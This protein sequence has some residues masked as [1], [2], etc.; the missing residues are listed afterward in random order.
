MFG[1]ILA[2]LLTVSLIVAVF[3]L[4]SGRWTA[5]KTATVSVLTSF[6]VL[7]RLPFAAIPGVQMTT[8]FVIIAG[9]HTGCRGGTTCGMAAAFLSNFFLGQGPWTPWQMLAWGGCGFAAGLLRR[10]FPQPSLITL[11]AFGA[12]CAFFAALILNFHSWL[13]YYKPLTWQ[14]YLAANIISIPYDLTHAGTNA[15]LLFTLAKPILRLLEE[16]T[17][18]TKE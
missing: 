4:E 11:A 7:G 15:I 3:F 8:F 6:A 9:L 14:T 10:S 13:Y 17:P 16:L 2:I 12:A 18:N 5:Q 1:T